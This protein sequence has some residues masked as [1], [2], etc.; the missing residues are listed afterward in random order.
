MANDIA[1]FFGGHQIP[2]REKLSEALAGYAAGKSQLMGKAL[3]RFTKTGTWVFGVDNE[4]LELGTKLVGNPMSLSSG[5]IAWWMSKV[6]GEVMQ[7]LSLGPV[8]ASKL[9]PV[10]SGGIP[11]G[12]KKPSGRGWEPQSAVDLLTRD[13][14]P[15]GMVYKTSSLGGMKALLGLSGDISYGLMEDSRRVYP[16]IELDSDSYTHKEYG[17]VFIPVLNL[18]GWLD[19]AGQEVNDLKKLL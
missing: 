15:L 16:I 6:E 9:A 4:A 17:Q 3:L 12:A 7:P 1:K 8:D 13:A 18:V 19:E 14:V 10:S 2:S 5:Y 11:P